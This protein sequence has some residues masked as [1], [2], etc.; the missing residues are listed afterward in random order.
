MRA[1][2]EGYAERFHF[3]EFLILPQARIFAGEISIHTEIIDK[4]AR[5]LL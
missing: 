5:Q 2:D 1:A 3:R 4:I